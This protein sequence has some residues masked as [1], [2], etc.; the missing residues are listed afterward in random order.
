M[1]GKFLR[2]ISSPSKPFPQAKD[3]STQQLG[4]YYFLFQ[5]DPAKL[6]RL[7]HSFDEDGIPM[8]SAYIDVEE[9]RLH[10]YPISIGQYG[11]ARYHRWLW[12]G[13]IEAKQQFINCCFASISPFQSQR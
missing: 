10:Y 9:P 4:E 11:L 6:N 12:N 2:D 3:F 8:N 7:I 13:D 1:A 5:D